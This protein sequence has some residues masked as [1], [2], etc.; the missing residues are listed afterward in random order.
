MQTFKL[1][2]S[3]VNSVILLQSYNKNHEEQNNSQLFSPS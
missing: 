2:T 3:T 1:N